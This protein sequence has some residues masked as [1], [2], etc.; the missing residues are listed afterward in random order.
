V[1]QLYPRALGFPPLGC[2]KDQEH[3]QIQ[4]QVQVQVI[5][6][7]MV[8]QTVSLGVGP[9]TGAHDQSFV[10]HLTITSFLMWG[11]LSD[12]RTGL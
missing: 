7:S 5:L 12:E 2:S 4:V 6:L 1:V 11:T 8:S 9:Q 3:V 10:F